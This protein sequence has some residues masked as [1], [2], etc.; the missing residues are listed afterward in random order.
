MCTELAVNAPPMRES[1]IVTQIAFL[2]PS[3]SETHDWEIAPTAAPMEKRAL[4][5]PRILAVYAVVAAKPCQFHENVL[6][7]RLTV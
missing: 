6:L 3:L 2:R 5:A 4:T 1:I 7:G